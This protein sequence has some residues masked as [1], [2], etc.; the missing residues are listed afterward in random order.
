[1]VV[2]WVTARLL[3]SRELRPLNKITAAAR[4]GETV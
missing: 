2:C 1:L 4:L 3:V